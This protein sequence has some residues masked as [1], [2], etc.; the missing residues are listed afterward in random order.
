[1]MGMGLGLQLRGGSAGEI[2]GCLG[3]AHA[4]GLG[5]LRAFLLCFIFFLE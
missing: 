3:V 2:K 4:V 5:C 1:M